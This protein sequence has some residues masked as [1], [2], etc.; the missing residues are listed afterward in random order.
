VAD[1]FGFSGPQANRILAVVR[2]V[3]SALRGEG[4]LGRILGPPPGQSAQMNYV[5]VTGDLAGDRYPGL[6]QEHIAASNTWVDKDAVWLRSANN[7]PLF[8]NVRYPARR[9]AVYPPDG[10]Q[11]YMTALESP[12]P[13]RLTGGS[14]TAYSW[15]EVTWTGTCSGWTTRTGGKTGTL[16]AY[17]RNCQQGIPAGTIVWLYN[18]GLGGDSPTQ[19][20]FDA[21]LPTVEDDVG[22][23]SV[24]YTKTLQ[25]DHDHFAVTNPAPNVAH[26]ARLNGAGGLIVQ[27]DDGFPVIVNPPVLEFDHTDFIV[28]ELGPTPQLPKTAHVEANPLDW[29]ELAPQDYLWR[30]SPHVAWVPVPTLPFGGPPPPNYDVLGTTCP[31]GACLVWFTCSTLFLAPHGFG[32]I[33][34]GGGQILWRINGAPHTPAPFIMRTGSSMPLTAYHQWCLQTFMWMHVG[35]AR[36]YFIHAQY[37]GGPEGDYQGFIAEPRIGFHQIARP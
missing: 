29:G 13:V 19:Y 34:T 12:L 23:T 22:S 37:I 15:V 18:F 14:V 2:E 28:T 5:K 16:N 17:E 8:V 11:V 31:D 26:V 35:P 1:V 3:E 6:W 25:F 10:K 21:E 27:E 20:V 4:R 33:D 36:S 24:K 32:D 30:V 7:E 9:M